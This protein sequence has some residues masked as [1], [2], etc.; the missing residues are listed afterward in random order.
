MCPPFKSTGTSFKDPTGVQ[1]SLS[2]VGKVLA[3]DLEGLPAFL[4]RLPDLKKNC[5]NF[6]QSRQ[7]PKGSGRGKTTSARTLER[8]DRTLKRP[9][10]LFKESQNFEKLC[11][12][13]EG[14]AR[15]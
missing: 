13:L 15:L 10:E 1:K 14:S 12:S 6:F 5:L 3:A 7:S 11:Q 8:V 9:A 4:K 2:T